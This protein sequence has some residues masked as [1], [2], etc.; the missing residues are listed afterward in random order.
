MSARGHSTLTDFEGSDF[1]STA[2]AFSTLGLEHEPLLDAISREVS[3]KIASLGAQQLGTLADLGLPCHMAV[4]S[5]LR[6]VIG[7]FLP[8][9]PGLVADFERGHYHR[10]VTEL[11][12]DNFGTCGD[13]SLLDRLGIEESPPDFAARGARQVAE[14]NERHKESWW[15]S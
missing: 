13:R 4:E 9:I 14:Y 10:L 15:R 8:H 3:R 7:C 6:E 12:V 11:E 1:S 2:W 5:R